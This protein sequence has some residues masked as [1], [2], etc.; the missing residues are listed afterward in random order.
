MGDAYLEYPEA[1]AGTV[2]VQW[3]VSD[4][5][6]LRVRRGPCESRCKPER[7]GHQDSESSTITAQVR[8]L[9]CLLSR[10]Q[11]LF[12]PKGHWTD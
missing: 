11:V 6:H 8:D 5:G 10:T 3:P 2:G 12:Y 9:C 7:S 1:R 4:H